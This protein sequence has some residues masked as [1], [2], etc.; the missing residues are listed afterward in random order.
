MRT[1]WEVRLSVRGE[2]K[3]VVVTVD[4][5]RMKQAAAEVKA[6]KAEPGWQDDDVLC[7]HSRYLRDVP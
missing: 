7:L 3:T 1:E 5:E 4:D 2:R 6:I